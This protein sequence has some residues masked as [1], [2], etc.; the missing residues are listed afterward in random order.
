[1]DCHGNRTRVVAAAQQDA[2]N[3]GGV[4][5]PEMCG[6]FCLFLRGWSHLRRVSGKKKR[7]LKMRQESSSTE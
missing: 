7:R 4:R 2:V 3:M 5:L 1:M 6:L